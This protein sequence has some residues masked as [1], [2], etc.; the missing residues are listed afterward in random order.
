[1]VLVPSGIVFIVGDQSRI[2]VGFIGCVGVAEFAEICR[3][4][5]HCAGRKPLSCLIS[6]GRDELLSRGSLVRVQHGS[7]NN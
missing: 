6:I 7:S 4:V 2:T 1:V 5:P 3:P